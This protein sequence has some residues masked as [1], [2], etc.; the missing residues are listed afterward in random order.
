MRG[1]HGINQ[2]TAPLLASCLLLA[3]GCGGRSTSHEL[4]ASGGAASSRGGAASSR[5]GAAGI[6]SNG[7]DLAFAGTD[8]SSGS[9]GAAAEAPFPSCAGLP[10]NC[11]SSSDDHCCASLTVPGGTFT[12]GGTSGTTSAT[13]T[14]F[15]LDKYEV[16]VGRF[17]NFVAAYS[18][19]PENGAGASSLLEGS[20]WQSPA[21]DSSIAATASS[22]S[23]AVQ[24]DS[25]Y[26]TWSESGDNDELPMNCVDWYEA[27][28]F[29]AWD[30][31]RLPTEAEWEYAA[32]GGES[33]STY[34]WG[35][36]P[37]LS[38]AL[39][40]TAAYANYNCL[41]DGS[42]PAT[43]AFTDIL[44]V[45]SKPMGA[46]KYG[47]LDLAG[48]VDEWLLDWYAD[49]PAA[50]EN[51]ANLSMPEMLPTLHDASTNRVVR[52]GD[53]L[54]VAVGLTA[55]YRFHDRSDGR[56]DFVGFRCARSAL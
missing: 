36:T 20:G 35:N 37:A 4:A 54:Y 32:S 26:Q 41:G 24:C 53:W 3:A 42:A 27:F 7:G 56:Y 38:D 18:G 55:Q 30:G 23:A 12:L 48:S 17:R 1:A 16:T 14:T 6:Q 8:E 45:G 13:V 44:K 5:G 19:H 10:A 34:P 49:Y 2:R 29:C 9:A 25:T 51:C 39:D 43:C 21:W 40:S 22:L 33:E 11:G 50:C 46:G 52:G 47:Q 28:A 31:G 15:A